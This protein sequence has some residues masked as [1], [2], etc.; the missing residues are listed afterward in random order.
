MLLPYLILLSWH[1]GWNSGALLTFFVTQ[2]EHGGVLLANLAAKAFAWQSSLSL[3][4]TCKIRLWC[5][6]GVK[7]DPVRRARR[8]LLA[9]VRITQKLKVFHLLH[10]Q[11]VHAPSHP[12]VFS[13]LLPVKLSLAMM[14]T[15]RIGLHGPLREDLKRPEKT[16]AGLAIDEVK[17]SS[18]SG[19]NFQDVLLQPLGE[20][21]C[22]RVDLHDPVGGFEFF[23]STD[24]FECLDKHFCV[25]YV[26]YPAR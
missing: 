23:I 19:G 17:C 20:E 25:Q 22:V 3:P 8:G 5:L 15:I 16:K 1:C 18:T 12:Q 14:D 4:P 13:P 26:F 6:E 21:Y 24:G 2:D 10:L 9:A 11:Q 7:C